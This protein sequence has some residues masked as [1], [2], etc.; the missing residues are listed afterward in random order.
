ML[1]ILGALGSRLVEGWLGRMAD[2]RS[3][4]RARVEAAIA[5]EQKLAQS[6]IDWDIEWAR[7]A[8]SSWKD[9]FFT[10]ILT[11]PLI[12]AAFYP[13]R[14]REMFENLEAVPMWWIVAW[15]VSVSA[16]FGYRKLVNLVLGLLKR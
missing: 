7:Q 5:R 16:A 14:I 4:E 6:E 9:E 12:A 3:L 10:I 11:A 1:K 8:Q 13:N 2:K 15:T